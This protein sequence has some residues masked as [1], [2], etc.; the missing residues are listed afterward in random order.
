MNKKRVAI[1][2]MVVVVVIAGILAGVLLPRGE[3]TNISSAAT[4]LM[5]LAQ[6]TRTMQS[7]PTPTPTPTP[8]L[9]TARQ[10]NWGDPIRVSAEEF[11]ANALA[12]KYPKLTV[13][14]VSGICY[15]PEVKDPN[16]FL[17]LCFGPEIDG[18]YIMVYPDAFDAPNFV[19]LEENDIVTIK[20]CYY[21]FYENG[22]GILPKGKYLKEDFIWYNALLLDGG[23]LISV[24][25]P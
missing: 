23:V 21:G 25:K 14:E 10:I 24:E 6:T 7:T 11:V 1:I 4:E 18:C 17:H 2:A 3:K 13:I 5:Q 8:P 16:T 20:G 19:H 9:E 22:C 15:K 12:G